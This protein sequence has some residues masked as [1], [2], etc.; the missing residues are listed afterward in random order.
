MKAAASKIGMVPYFD[1]E[2]YLNLRRVRPRTVAYVFDA[3]VVLTPPEIADDYT[4]IINAAVTSGPNPDGPVKALHIPAQLPPANPFSPQRMA[5]HNVPRRAVATDDLG[6]DWREPW[7][8]G[9]KPPKYTKKQR[10]AYY[11]QFESKKKDDLKRHSENMLQV[12]TKTVSFDSLP[13]PHLLPGMLCR[14]VG[15][16]EDQQVDERFTLR[17][18]FHPLTANNPMTIGT[19]KPISANWKSIHRRG[20]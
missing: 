17:S 2:G 7:N 1:G 6:W 11:L 10:D 5:R 18:G 8:R 9:E 12:A 4:T 3:E 16:Y 20:A 14:I 19:W 13:V 15:E